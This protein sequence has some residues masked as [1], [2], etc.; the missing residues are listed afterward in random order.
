MFKQEKKQGKNP[1]PLYAK[2]ISAL[3]LSLI[4]TIV[5]T[6]FMLIVSGSTFLA[7]SLFNLRVDIKAIILIALMVVIYALS[8]D[9]IFKTIVTYILGRN[10]F[11]TVIHNGI[12][13]LTML[14]IGAIVSLDTNTN[15]IV[16]GVLTLLFLLV[17][18]A[19]FLDE[20]TKAASS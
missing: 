5:L 2:I 13:F 10:I 3:G 19:D 12:R 14:L 9:K 6:V 15:F 1:D 20:R 16:A 4:L 11:T 17:D 7:N 8:F 18:I